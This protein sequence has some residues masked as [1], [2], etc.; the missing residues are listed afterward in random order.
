[1]KTGYTQ[2]ESCESMKKALSKVT[3]ELLALRH[4]KFPAHQHSGGLLSNPTKDAMPATNLDET[5][6]FD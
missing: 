1:V 6:Q 5:K 2:K 3:I 4:K